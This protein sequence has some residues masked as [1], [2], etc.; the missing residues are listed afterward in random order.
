MGIVSVLFLVI[1]CRYLF[2]AMYCLQWLLLVLHIYTTLCINVVQ[3]RWELLYNTFS[4]ITKPSCIL[5]AFDYH[6]M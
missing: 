5:S 3:Y 4:I 1:Q 2:S 6:Y